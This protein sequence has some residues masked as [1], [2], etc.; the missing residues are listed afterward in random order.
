MLESTSHHSQKNVPYQYR[1]S[2]DHNHYNRI[3]SQG[4][5]QPLLQPLT[6]NQ[7]EKLYYAKSSTNIQSTD[8]R[9]MRK[10]L[11]FAYSNP[12]AQ[13]IIQLLNQ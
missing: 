3:G 11:T 7:Q 9:A 10:S 2:T 4:N 6:N 1:H 5:F 8:S 13:P 12:I